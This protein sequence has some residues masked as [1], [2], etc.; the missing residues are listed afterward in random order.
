[1]LKKSASGVLLSLRRST[2]RSVRLAASPAVVLPVERRVLARL[3][4]PARVDESARR[5]KRACRGW[6]GE[7]RSL[8]EHPE[9]ILAPA[10]HGRF[11]PYRRPIPRFSE[12]C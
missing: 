1:M 11:S 5:A 9:V 12:A 8:F 6:A 7:I 2:Y 10:Q 4:E 3:D